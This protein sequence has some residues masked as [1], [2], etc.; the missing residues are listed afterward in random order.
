MSIK[1][2]VE[3]IVELYLCYGKQSY[4]EKCSQIQ[5]AEQ[6]GNLALEWGW[7]EEL[8][9][10][11]YL[12]D[13][14]HFVAQHQSHPDFTAFGC[15]Q[16]DEIGAEYLKQKGFSQR[17]QMLVAEHVN[18]KRYLAATEPGYLSQLS[19]ASQQTLKIQGG[20]MTKE[21]VMKYQTN[22]YL[23]DIIKLRRLDDSGKQ[24][25]M[26]SKSIEYW[27]SLMKKHLR[28]KKDSHRN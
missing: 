9:L 17:I 15:P 13:I 21:Q 26:E 6:S 24:P 2:T 8:A 7:D 11:A 10:A 23:D 19:N 20:P 28:N 18:V 25:E 1:S 16:H 5:H 4:E 22:P 12:H 3:E 27:Q 14:G